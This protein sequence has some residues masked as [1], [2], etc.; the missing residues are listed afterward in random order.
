MRS[1]DKGTA[2]AA[3]VP[4][5]CD[6]DGIACDAD[7]ASEDVPASSAARDALRSEPAGRVA[8]LMEDVVGASKPRT[9]APDAPPTPPV[10]LARPPAATP[11]AATPALGR[12]P[13]ATC[14]TGP[15]VVPSPSPSPLT[16]G[17]KGEGIEGGEGLNDRCAPPEDERCAPVE[18]GSR[19]RLR[20]V[21][22]REAAA[23]PMA[24]DA[25]AAD[26]EAVDGGNAVDGNAVDEAP[27]CVDTTPVIP[28]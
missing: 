12:S 2:D 25:R 26:R 23:E 11:T 27:P 19:L 1:L 22:L 9:V 18:L 10:R 5:T 17:L 21:A 15:R 20:A 13:R 7:A 24:L 8:A 6:E 4:N 16:L 14:P 28:R 3:C